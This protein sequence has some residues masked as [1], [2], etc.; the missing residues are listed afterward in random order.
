[1]LILLQG[2]PFLFYLYYLHILI[3]VVYNYLTVQIFTYISKVLRT[4]WNNK[5]MKNSSAI[6]ISKMNLVSRIF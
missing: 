4:A 1:M 6:E 5:V 2:H 3:T